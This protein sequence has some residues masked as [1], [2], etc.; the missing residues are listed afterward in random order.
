M[1]CP[2]AMPSREIGRTA[3]ER[4]AGSLGYA[5][6]LIIY[7]NKNR[8]ST[9]SFERLYTRKVP[10]K[11]EKLE[12]ELEKARQTASNPLSFTDASEV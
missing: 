9:L 4:K 1:A 5:E 2:P 10:T 12:D 3:R 6:T 7:Y 8:K 11:K